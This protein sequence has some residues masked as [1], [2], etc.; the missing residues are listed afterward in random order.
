MILSLGISLLGMHFFVGIFSEIKIICFAVFITLI[1]LLFRQL[2]DPDGLHQTKNHLHEALKA[3]N[4]WECVSKLHLQ[5]DE[6]INNLSQSR[7]QQLCLARCFIKKK[8][9]EKLIIIVE[10]PHPDLLPVL[11]TCLDDGLSDNTVIVISGI[12]DQL[13]LCENV[14]TTEDL[15][16]E[17]GLFIGDI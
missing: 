6:P 3:T 11:E 9:V 10:Y 15:H 12:D 2:L 7:R 8:T 13:K 14:T 1:F 17:E 5:L 4:M 16:L